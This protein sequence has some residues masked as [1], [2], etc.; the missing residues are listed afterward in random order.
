MDWQPGGSHNGVQREWTGDGEGN[1]TVR[2]SQDVT[3]L[4]D[5]N[6]AMATHNDGYSQSRELRRVASIPVIV[7]MQ[8]TEQYG[9]NPV[10]A[11]DKTLLMRLLN[12]SD[13]AHLRTAEGVLGVSNGVLR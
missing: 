5:R 9:F 7:Q 6:K 2:F 8:W 1:L 3:P 12:S 10:Y 13:Y 4:L 11:Q